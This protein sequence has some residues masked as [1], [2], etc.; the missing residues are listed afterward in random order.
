MFNLNVFGKRF[1]PVLSGRFET[2]PSFADPNS[3]VN[4]SYLSNSRSNLIK[5]H[6][7]QLSY[8]HL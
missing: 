7:N 6:G 2:V 8:G 3:L 1:Q 5:I 4:N